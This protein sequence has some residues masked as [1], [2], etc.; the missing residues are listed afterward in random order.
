MQLVKIVARE[1]G[2]RKRKIE[3]LQALLTDPEACKTNFASFEPLP[4]PL[5]PEI[6][7]KGVVPEKASLFNVSI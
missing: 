2:N 4:L 1:S 6:I 5:D 3:R 7:V